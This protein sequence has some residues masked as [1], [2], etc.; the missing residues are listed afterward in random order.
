M[1]FLATEIIKK[2]RDKKE[3]SDEEIQFFISGYLKNEIADYQLSAWLMAVV[4]NGMTEKE[5]VTLMR[6]MLDSGITMDFSHLNAPA[7]DKHSSGGVGDKTSLILAPIVAA[8]DLYVPMISGRGLGHTGGTLDKLESIPG[9]TTT[10]PLEKFKKLVE[11]HG[12]CFMGQ[13]KDICPSDK[14][15]YALRDVTGTV[16]SLPLICASIMSKK[17]AEGIDALVLDIKCGSGAFMKTRKDARELAKNLVRVG[18]RYGKKVTALV[19]QMEQP[20]GRFV[21]NSL[22][23][24]ECV[25]ILKN[26]N[27]FEFY[28]E[29][30]ELSLLLAGHMAL[31]AGKY[32]TLQKAIAA[33]EEVIAN[34]KAFEKFEL[35][36]KAQGGNLSKLPRATKNRQVLA[37]RSGYM[38]KMNSEEIGQAAIEL[39]AGRKKANDVIDPSAGIEVFKKIGSPIKKG[40]VLFTIFGSTD[41]SLATAAK[42]LQSA[43]VLGT[44]KV[45][46]LNLHLETI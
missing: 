16:E 36:V 8:L 6:V 3:N 44:K 18:R 37:P 1:A 39:G 22:E 9:L 19:T 38:T 42:R 10:L 2:K 34:G 7:V 41:E 21:G 27:G 5:T 17:V 20:L 32:K 33:C 40:D 14:K 30:R 25:S 43:F 31:L 26:E 12:L 13:T 29:T 45:K 28:D 46:K 23:I 15:I 11:K 35:I 4:L 24:E